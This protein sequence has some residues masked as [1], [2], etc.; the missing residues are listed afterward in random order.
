MFLEP[1]CSTNLNLKF[2]HTKLTA[3]VPIHQDVYMTCVQHLIYQLD[4]NKVKINK[5]NFCF[6]PSYNL[7]LVQQSNSTTRLNVQKHKINRTAFPSLLQISASQGKDLSVVG[8]LPPGSY[9][10]VLS[11]ASLVLF[12]D[13]PVL[14]TVHGIL[15]M[16]DDEDL[17]LFYTLHFNICFLSTHL[18]NEVMP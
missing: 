5:F 15:P 17:D 9:L 4:L 6:H 10:C 3:Y 2:S 1:H 11:N 18:P 14:D 7:C 12:L 8:A 16:E 13:V